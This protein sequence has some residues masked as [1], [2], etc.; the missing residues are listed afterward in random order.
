VVDRERAKIDRI[1]ERILALLNQRARVARR[2]GR[3]K[4]QY[5]AEEANGFWVP[6]REKRVLDRLRDLNH[7]PLG[8]D[9]VRAIFREIISASR[10]LETSITVAYLGPEGTFA[11]AAARERFG[12]GVRLLPLESI[13]QVF[14]EVEQRR[15]DF[16]VVPVENS[17]E[18]SVTSTLDLLIESPL[19][20]TAEIM[21]KVRQ[22]LLSRARSLA[23]VR[24]VL[25]HP[26]G[27]AQ[28]RRWLAGHLP[29]AELEEVASTSRA[30]EMAS[31]DP[32]AAAIASRLAAE[33][34]RLGVLAAD[35]Q[36]ERANVTRF[37]VLGTSDAR[38]P[39]GDDKTSVI[40]TV[41][42]EV[43]I[44]ARLLQP[45]AREKISLQKIESRPLRGRPWEYVFFLDLRGHRSDV[46]VK[47][48]LN[49]MTPYTTL[50]KILG[51]YPTGG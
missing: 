50:M 8:D 25:S 44:L 35:I 3:Q 34:Y 10:A 9:G 51:S 26:Q 12:A 36:D 13:P 31:T 4:L 5:G 29:H 6:A 7:G 24:R 41:K 16:G 39:S 49:R 11:H 2:I 45:L 17:T 38:A 28:C 30:A 46:K 18:G 19:Q 33:R 22:C 27:L 20:V 37:F 32:R 1:D 21:L 40:C 15:V 43:G 23:Q 42:D 48:A 14:R 47:R